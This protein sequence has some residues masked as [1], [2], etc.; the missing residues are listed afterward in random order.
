[1]S[2]RKVLVEHQSRGR[3]QF[4][5]LSHGLGAQNKEPLIL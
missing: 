2:N 1:M 5:I 3:L 4:P